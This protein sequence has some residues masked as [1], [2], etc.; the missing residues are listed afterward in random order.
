MPTDATDYSEQQRRE[1]L[2]YTQALLAACEELARS[3]GYSLDDDA[4]PTGPPDGIW[5]PAPE[6]L[7]N[8]RFDWRADLARKAAESAEQ[9]AS[10]GSSGTLGSPGTSGTSGTSGTHPSSATHTHETAKQFP[11]SGS[12]G[13]SGNASADSAQKTTEQSPSLGSSGS[14]RAPFSRTRE[15]ER[16]ITR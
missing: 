5:R 1:A 3:R 14:S 12:S 6:I 9:S 8:P 2:E 15:G 13:S 10:S 7:T 11:T 4:D 16:E